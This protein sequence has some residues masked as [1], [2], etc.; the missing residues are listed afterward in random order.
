[1]LVP[2]LPSNT[3]NSDGLSIHEMA[4]KLN[5]NLLTK[6][7]G[8]HVAI[9]MTP[10]AYYLN[11]LQDRGQKDRVLSTS[12]FQKILHCCTIRAQ[13]AR[14]RFTYVLAVKRR[15]LREMHGGEMDVYQAWVFLRA[16][17]VF[18]D[19]LTF[20]QNTHQTC[21]FDS[22]TSAVCLTELG[23]KSHQADPEAL[24]A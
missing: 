19:V 6:W 17:L 4:N 11:L 1:M 10:R 18:V 24:G 15:N 12:V 2:F 8:F 3:K 23:R 9:C 20:R 22:D 7:T 5:F 13:K 21:P 14:G 16:P